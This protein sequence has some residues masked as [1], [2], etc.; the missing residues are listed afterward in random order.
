M[1]QMRFRVPNAKAFDPRIW[2]TAFISSYD[3]FPWPCVNRVENDLLIIERA[4]N[5]S[6]KVS[7]V[8]PTREYGPILLTSGS[9]RC[10]EEPYL[11]PL[12]LA[13]G[14][15]HRIRGRGINWQSVG[16]KLPEA[17]SSLIDQAVSQF[18]RAI[19]SKDD[20]DVCTAL[21]QDS[22]DLAISASRPLARAFV[23]QSLQARHAVE[24]QF[25]TLLGV[26]A[27]NDP[28][29]HAS[30]ETVLP[31]INT[32]N[33]PMEMGQLQSD[34]LKDQMSRIDAQLEWARTHSLR[35]FGGPLLNLQP[36]AFPKWFHLENDFES[37]FQAA[38]D[39]ARTMVERYRGQVHLWSAASGLNAPN[40]IGLS[41]EQVQ[42][43]A[44][45]VI[46]TVR[47]CDPKTPVIICIDAPWAEYLAHQPDGI[48]PLIFAE[49]LIR[50]D[51]GLSGI[52]LEM[53]LNLWPH[54]SLPR[55]LVD[56]SDMI[57]HWGNALEMPL[58]AVVTNPYNA[59]PDANAV[60]KSQIVSTWTY[61]EFNVEACPD[62]ADAEDDAQKSVPELRFP[63]NA[64]EILQLLLAKT[65]IH[66]IVWN[67]VSD[68]QE[69]PFPNSGLIGPQG[70]ARGL[71]DGLVRLR[72]LHVH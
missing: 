6:G 3:G 50:V 52:G 45:G 27:G 39:H 43:L 8:W 59:I 58:L 15:I 36:H 34:V 51:L 49:A 11:L 4:E 1:G 17:Y 7:V 48:S 26:R 16:L 38:C 28:Q 41:D 35:V 37:L 55:D 20:I 2:N 29:W 18:L 71:L 14:T 66:G 68:Q 57:D 19:L 5:E 31:A 46:Q 67:Q 21:S 23:S 54:G 56:I 25:S 47:R 42:K 44:I 22:I 70:R 69:H 64:M 10:V 53:N 9:L 13:R 24:K 40:A 60:A 61:P 62:V 63:A 32:L 33:V 12:E 72:Q 65:R 30:A